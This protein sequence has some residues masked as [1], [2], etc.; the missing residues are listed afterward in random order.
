[1]VFLRL[2]EAGHGAARHAV[3]KKLHTDEYKLYFLS[4]TKSSVDGKWDRV[5]FTDESTFSSANDGLVLVY[6]P[7]GEHYTLQYMSPSTRSGLVPVH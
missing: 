3:V 7:W 2:K 5:I 6:R 4:F 1:M